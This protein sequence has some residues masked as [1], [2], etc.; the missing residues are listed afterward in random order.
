V[1]LAGDIG[2]TKTVLAVFDEAGDRLN[3][4]REEVYP[5]ASAA[6]LEELGI[7]FLETVGRPAVRAACFGVAGAVVDGRAKA[8]NLP[9]QIDE[10]VLSSALGI[11]PVRLLNDLEAAAYGVLVLPPESLHTLQDGTP[12]KGGGTMALIAAGTGLG[13]AILP[14]DGQ[15]HRVMASEGGH[16]DFGP[17]NELEAALWEYLRWEFGHVSWER[18]LSGPGFMNIYHFLRRHRKL[19]EPSWLTDEIK[20]GTPS[21]VVS[22]AGLAGKDPVCAE[23]VVL[24]IW[25]SRRWPWVACSSAAASRRRCCRRSRWRRSSTPSPRRGA[26]PRSSGTFPSTSS[27]TLAHRCWARPPTPAPCSRAGPMSVAARR[28]RSQGCSVLGRRGLY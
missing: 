1:I 16:V 15:V 2:G 19:V 28:P 13:E 21:A 12:P 5:S 10:A 8:T 22:Q 6:S 23:T 14:W 27:W 20:A 18:V 17:R 24:F 4:V 3:L 7:K 9:W 11:T 26:W 25:R